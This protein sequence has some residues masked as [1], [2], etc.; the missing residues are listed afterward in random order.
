MK[1]IKTKN[2]KIQAFKKIIKSNLQTVEQ[3]MKMR[4]RAEK[5][6]IIVTEITETNTRT[7]LALKAMTIELHPAT[8]QVTTAIEAVEETIEIQVAAPHQS[9]EEI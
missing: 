8:H 5:M 4:T 9:L 3:I 7:K 1:N 6:I 2:H